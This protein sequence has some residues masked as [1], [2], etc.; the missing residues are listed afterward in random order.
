MTLKQRVLAGWFC[1]G[2]SF[3]LVVLLATGL[4]EPPGLN[5]A[6]SLDTLLRAFAPWLGAGLVLFVAGLLLLR[7]GKP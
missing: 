7:R 5:A 3:A 6:H 4:F 1:I 2:A